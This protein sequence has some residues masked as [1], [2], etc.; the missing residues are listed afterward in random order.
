MKKRLFFV[1][2]HDVRQFFEN[3]CQST[4]SVSV[5]QAVGLN[6]GDKVP[7]EKITQC[8]L[9]PATGQVNIGLPF[10]T[11]ILDSPILSRDKSLNCP[12]WLAVY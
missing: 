3:P 1:C 7:Y 5:S 11:P 4:I 8:Y 10:F 12:R 6:S 2:D 9:T